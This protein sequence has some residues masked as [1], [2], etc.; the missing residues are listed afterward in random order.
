VVQTLQ[1]DQVLGQMF[2]EGLRLR[3][4]RQNGPVQAAC[5]AM[6]DQA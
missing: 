3:A 6:L 4:G 1:S 5:Q 2:L